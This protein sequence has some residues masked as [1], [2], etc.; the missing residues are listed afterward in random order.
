MFAPLSAGLWG[1]NSIGIGNVE[2]NQRIIK[3]GVSIY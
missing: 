3:E 2:R 1:S